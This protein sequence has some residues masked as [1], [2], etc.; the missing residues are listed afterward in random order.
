MLFEMG[1]CS[2]SVSVGKEDGGQEAAT[3]EDLSAGEA[4][5]AATEGEEDREAMLTFIVAEGEGWENLGA[6]FKTACE[7]AGVPDGCFGEGDGRWL[8][9]VF[10][11]LRKLDFLVWALDYYVL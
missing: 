4:D 9:L 6:A 2:C 1:A 11:G 8:V 5:F 10:A 3:D 7:L